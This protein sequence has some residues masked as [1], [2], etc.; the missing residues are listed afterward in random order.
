MVS[1]HLV[2]G[3]FDG[4]SPASRAL[5]QLLGHLQARAHSPAGQGH[6]PGLQLAGLQPHV[7]DALEVTL[8]WPSAQGGYLQHAAV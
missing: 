1:L 7:E 3:A 4:A 2:G 6:V 8:L 5:A